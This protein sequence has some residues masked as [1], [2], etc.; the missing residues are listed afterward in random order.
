MMA[1]LR[2]RAEAIGRAAQRRRLE[3][4]AATIRDSGLAAEV[5]PDSVRFSGRS[6]VR[7]WL[8]DPLLRFAGRIEA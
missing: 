5:G 6:L 7:Q 3:D 2:A 1:A 8:S 4:I